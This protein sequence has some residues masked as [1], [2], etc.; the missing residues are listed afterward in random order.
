MGYST[1]F[2][3]ALVT[4]VP[5]TESTEFAPSDFKSITSLNQSQT[6]GLINLLSSSRRMQRNLPA[7]YGIEGEF[8]VPDNYAKD[9]GQSEDDSIVNYNN[10]PRT[11]PS[12]WLGWEIVPG[13]EYYELVWDGTEKFYDY[14]E[15]LKYL[16]TTFFIPKGIILHGIIEWEGEDW[17]DLGRLKVVNNVLTIDTFRITYEDDL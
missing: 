11:Q 9:A 1:S 6:L 10:P 14:A 3:G 13:N 15:W 16:L 12:L 8:F 2:C 5:I 7:N 4:N 17:G